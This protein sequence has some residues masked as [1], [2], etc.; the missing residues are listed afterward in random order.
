[1]YVFTFYVCLT[2]FSTI[3]Q[4]YHVVSFIVQGDQKYPEKNTDVSQVT[5]KLYHMITVSTTTIS[6]NV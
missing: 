2:P 4:F 3:F 1:M 5:D 6:Y